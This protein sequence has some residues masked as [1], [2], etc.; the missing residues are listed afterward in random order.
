MT[1]K[2]KLNSFFRIYKYYIVGASIGFLISIFSLN[3]LFTSKLVGVNDIIL[4][5]PRK[6]AMLTYGCLLCESY[7][8]TVPILLILI[9]P[10]SGIFITFLIRKIKPN[11]NPR[12]NK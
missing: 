8:N 10:L 4:Y 6:I 7:L 12:K 11:K 9:Y 3:Q 2:N 1:N 5:I